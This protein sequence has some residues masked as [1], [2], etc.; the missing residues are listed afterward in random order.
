MGRPSHAGWI[1]LSGVRE[2][3]RAEGLIPQTLPPQTCNRDDGPRR[4]FGQRC[5]TLHSAGVWAR[6]TRTE[7]EPFHGQRAP[8][9]DP[10]CHGLGG[11][12]KDRRDSRARGSED[13]TGVLE[14]LEGEV[15]VDLPGYNPEDPR[16]DPVSQI[17]EDPLQATN[18][19]RS[20]QRSS[21]LCR[22]SWR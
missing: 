19:R 17:P 7:E 6:G 3:L 12:K 1:P 20:T 18:Q 15:T 4:A 9:G 22:W 5:P 10:C 8:R 21:K 11:P 14:M 2:S 13:T 16:M